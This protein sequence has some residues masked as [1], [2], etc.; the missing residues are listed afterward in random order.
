LAYLC[1]ACQWLDHV[2]MQT[3]ADAHHQRAPV[4]VVIPK[5]S[6]QW[7]ASKDGLELIKAFTRLPKALQRSVVDLVERITDNEN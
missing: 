1:P 6:C 5:L 7:C 3:F 4:S 2:D